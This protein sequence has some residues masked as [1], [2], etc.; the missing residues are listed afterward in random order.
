M[1]IKHELLHHPSCLFP[2]CYNFLHLLYLL[3]HPYLHSLFFYPPYLVLL[4]FCFLT[5]FP[6]FSWFS[7]SF[8]SSS[9]LYFPLFTVLSFFHISHHLLTSSFSPSIF[10]SFRFPQYFQGLRLNP[11]VPFHHHHLHHPFFIP[12]RFFNYS[13][14]FTNTN[15]D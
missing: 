14:P 12:Q 5:S 3:Y 4:F 13:L 15:H 7:A 2:P 1:T 10:Q 6:T 9:L 8:P 11:F